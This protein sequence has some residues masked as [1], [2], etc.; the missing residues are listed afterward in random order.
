MD[1]YLGKKLD[2][3]YEMLEVIGVG[4]MAIVYKAMDTLTNN[5]VAFFHST[6]IVILIFSIY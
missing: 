1:K 2:G 6:K 4:G 3:R 5:I